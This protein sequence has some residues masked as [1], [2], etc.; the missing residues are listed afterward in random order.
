MVTFSETNNPTNIKEIDLIETWIGLNFPPEYKEHLIKYNGGRCSP[1]VFEF[2]ENGKQSSSCV[3]WFFAIYDGE[4]YKLRDEIE[5]VKLNE[6]RL[7]T[8]IIPI[9]C[10]PGGNLVCISC[11]SDD[12]GKVYFWDHENEVDYTVSGDDDYSNLYLIANSFNE[13]IDGLTDLELD[14]E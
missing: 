6:K 8:H 2:I 12:Y 13:F 5:M 1:N 11:G 10:D 14:D 9:A 4:Y 3:D 7:P